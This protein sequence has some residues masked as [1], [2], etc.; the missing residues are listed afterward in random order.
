M[1]VKKKK[2]KLKPSHKA[3]L[4]VVLRRL[5][6]VTT[7]SVFDFIYIHFIF[8][9]FIVV[10]P[11]FCYFHSTHVMHTLTLL[12]HVFKHEPQNR[13]KTTATT[14]ITKSRVPT[15]RIKKCW[16]S[17]EQNRFLWVIKLRGKSIKFLKMWLSASLADISAPPPSIESGDKCCCLC[18]HKTIKWP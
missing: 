18:V 3:A 13:R 17:S 1:I 2:K 12:S 9:H 6:M 16:P 8:C 4:F 10:C 11:C 15:K 14:A 7:V 5:W